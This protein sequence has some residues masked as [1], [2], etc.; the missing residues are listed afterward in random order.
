ML[1]NANLIDLELSASDKKSAI[2]QLA[3]LAEQEGRLSDASSYIL[4]VLDRESEYTTGVGGGI[5]IPHAKSM[6]VKEAMI[7]FGRFKD[8][9]EWN[10]ADGKPVNMIFL[11]GVPNENI[12][13]LHLK[14]L[15][16]LA[17]KIVSEEFLDILR[18]ASSKEELINCLREIQAC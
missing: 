5:A 8:G 1:I 16:Q 9:I 15:S 11:L 3:K 13:N 18:N 14:I 12:D 17:R 2:Q 10:A 7:V 4:D 6:A